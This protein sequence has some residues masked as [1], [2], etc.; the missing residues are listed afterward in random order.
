MDMTFKLQVFE[1]PLDLLLYLIEKNTVPGV[2][3]PDE[4][5]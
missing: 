5:G 1:G 3:G 2:C 4:K